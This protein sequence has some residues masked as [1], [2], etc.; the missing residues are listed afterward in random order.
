MRQLSFIFIPLISFLYEIANPAILPINAIVT[1]NVLYKVKQDQQIDVLKKPFH[2]YTTYGINSVPTPNDNG[3]YSSWTSHFDWIVIDPDA[4]GLNCR[5]S[6]AMPDDWYSPDAKWPRLNIREWSIVRQF[7]TN[8]H[9][10]ANGTPAGFVIIK[11]E[12]NKP[13]LKVS[14]GAD[15]KI[16]LVRANS[17]FIRPVQ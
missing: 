15:D 10:I 16:C 13:W 7:P 8:T 17:S 4:A 5:W 3:D 2:N 12:N 6:N 9:L 11:D 14:I 1:T